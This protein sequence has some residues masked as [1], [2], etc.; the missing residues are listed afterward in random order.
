MTDH[1][2]KI[3][4]T[5]KEN[6]IVISDTD[7]LSSFLWRDQFGIVTK[8]F[9]KLGMDIVIPQA[10]IEELGYSIR[11]R[12]RLQIPLIRL[13]NKKEKTRGAGDIYIRDIDP[14][15]DMGIK[16]NELKESMGQGESAA[17]SMLLYSEEK[18]ACLASNNLKDISKYVEDYGITLWTTADVVVKAEELGI[19]THESAINLWDKMLKDNLYLPEGSYEEYCKRKKAVV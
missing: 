9:A 16:Y 3:N 12:E 15:S 13:N 14:F 11:T 18:P 17:I 6:K 8:L 4:D 10:V 5:A 1:S 2:G 7:F 19:I